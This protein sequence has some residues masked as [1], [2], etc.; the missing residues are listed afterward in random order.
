VK[1]GK[2]WGLGCLALVA[3]PVL[4]LLVVGQWNQLPLHWRFSPSRWRIANESSR[5][6]MARDYLDTHTAVGMTLDQVRSDLGRATWEWDYWEY[7]VSYAGLGEPCVSCEPRYNDEPTLLVWFH[8]DGRRVSS[9]TGPRIDPP[10]LSTPFSAEAWRSC[11]HFPDQRRPLAYDLMQGPQL[12]GAT[13]DE[14]RASLGPPDFGELLLVYVVERG[15][16]DA[17]GLTLSV[18]DRDRVVSAK[19]DP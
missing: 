7:A 12:R 14:V 19:L 18:D 16:S 1:A 17:K 5:R 10:L 2:L 3:A 11:S 4:V 6:V 8:A 13:R 15:G 9:F